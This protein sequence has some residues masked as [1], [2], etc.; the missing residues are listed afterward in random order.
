M[1]VSDHGLIKYFTN[2][3][4]LSI[5]NVP[6]WCNMKPWH[7]PNCLAAS[8][9][10]LSKVR[11]SEIWHEKSTLGFISI[12]FEIA[13]VR[14]HTHCILYVAYPVHDGRYVTVKSRVLKW[15]R[16]NGVLF[17]FVC[18]HI[19]WNKHFR[20]CKPPS[21]LGFHFSSCLITPLCMC[22]LFSLVFLSNR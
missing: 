10:G 6:R 7:L 3:S 20:T 13:G 9:K 18:F 11:K 15:Q 21:F 19:H 12:E 4:F 16:R 2:P 8:S 17:K 5:S 14:C 1:K 22:I